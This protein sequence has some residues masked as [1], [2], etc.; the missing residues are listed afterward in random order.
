IS[1]DKGATWSSTGLLSSAV[2]MMPNNYYRGTTGERLMVDPQKSGL[3]YFCSRQNGLWKKNGAAA[4]AQ[5][6]GLPAA[7]DPGYS[8][9]VF[10]KSSGLVGGV[11]KTIYVGIYG[12][13]VWRS[14]DGG[15]TWA[16]IGGATNPSKAVV[17]PT[18]VLYL[19]CGQNED[20]TG[21]TTG[22]IKKYSG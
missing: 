8:F 5:V 14:T 15:S 11:T 10:D 16:S 6:G 12:N 21:G 4:W 3:L 13:G 19:A 7:A 17:S 9:I 1:N 2:A 22:S 18:G 20:E